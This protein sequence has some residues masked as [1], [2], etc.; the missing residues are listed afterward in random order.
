MTLHEIERRARQRRASLNARWAHMPV[1]DDDAVLTFAEWCALNGFSLRTGRR[2]L[3]SGNG[4]I[5]TQ[6]S[7]KRIGVTRGNNR[8]WQASRARA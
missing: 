5:I 6:L 3:A 1:N 8:A 7:A 4:P 2:I